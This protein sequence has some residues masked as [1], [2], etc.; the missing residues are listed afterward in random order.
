MRKYIY[1][2]VFIFIASGCYR[3]PVGIDVFKTEETADYIVFDGFAT[4]YYGDQFI[5][6]SQSTGFKINQRNPVLDAEVSVYS[7][8]SLYLF[9]LYDSSGTYCSTKPF[10]IE[11]GVKYTCKAIIDGKE[12][13]ASDSLAL[14]NEDIDTML[15]YP[16]EYY[17]IPSTNSYILSFIQHNFGYD[18]ASLYLLLYVNYFD[19][20]ESYQNMNMGYYLF[21]SRFNFLYK[22]KGVCPQGIYVTEGQS[23]IRVPDIDSFFEYFSIN[24]SDEYIDYFTD[25]FNITIWS[26]GIFSTVPGNAKTNVS[27]GGIGYFYVADVKRIRIKCG[28]YIKM[29]E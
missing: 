11:R 8:D 6:I 26:D 17:N 14:I 9:E 27:N 16:H 25:Y 28:D 24:V 22:H 2:I 10:A 18:C 4:T 12:Y 15:V 19:D 29:L 23:A 13:W 21:D 5:N 3:E 7:V 20:S 1:V